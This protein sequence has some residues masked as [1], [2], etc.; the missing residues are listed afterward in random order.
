MSVDN[1]PPASKAGRNLPVAIASG[2]ALAALFLGTLVTN[3]WL[4]LGFI[5][6][7]MGIALFELDHAFRGHGLRPL[8]PVAFGA[9][10]VMFFGTYRSGTSAQTLGLVLLLFGAMAGS[11]LERDRSRMAQ[12]LGATMLMAVWVPFLASFMGLLLGRPNG[13]WYVFAAVLLAVMN[14]IGAYAVGMRFGRHKMAPKVSP[15]KSWEGFGGGVATAMLAGVA[16][17]SPFV[18]DLGWAQALVLGAGVAIAGTLGDLAESM[19][20]RDLGVKDL[21]RIIPGHGGIMDR[22]D[23]IIFALPMVSLLLD[24]LQLS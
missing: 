21:G 3:P 22:A 19:V 9:G 12:S 11:L 16:I 24:V 15:A 18:P 7:L 2:L 8:T 5:G 14:D 13:R 20:K 1:P 4:L 23:A 17:L 6:I 10:F